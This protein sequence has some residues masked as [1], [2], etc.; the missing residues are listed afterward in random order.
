VL[1]NLPATTYTL[2]KVAGCGHR[3]AQEFE[4]ARDDVRHS[5]HKMMDIDFASEMK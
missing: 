3:Q 5:Q 2:D 1:R 4:A